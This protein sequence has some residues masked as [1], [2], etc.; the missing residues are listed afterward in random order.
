MLCIHDAANVEV[1]EHAAHKQA[2]ISHH[3]IFR[4]KRQPQFAQRLSVHE[5]AVL[6]IHMVVAQEV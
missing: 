4:V 6:V 5:H 2:F 3:D 1:G